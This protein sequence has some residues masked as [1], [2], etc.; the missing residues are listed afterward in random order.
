MRLHSLI[1]AALMAAMTTAAFAAP[2]T[3]DSL[4]TIF[5]NDELPACGSVV[6]GFKLTCVPVYG[7]Y[8]YGSTKQGWELHG[9]DL[10]FGQKQGRPPDG[11]CPCHSSR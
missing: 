10:T 8:L 7:P 9:N 4:S 5:A 1:A 2:V 6:D 3:N 11:C